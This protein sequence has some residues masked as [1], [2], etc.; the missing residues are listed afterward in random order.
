MNRI[1]AIDPEAVHRYIPKMARTWPVEDQP[2][3]LIKALKA[4]EAAKIQDGL[5]DIVP[6]GNNKDLS[7]MRIYSGSSILN[8]LVAGLSGWE[9][10]K[11]SNGEDAPWRDNNGTPRAENFDYIPSDIRKELA[12]QITEGTFLTEQDEK[13]SE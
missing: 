7:T 4:K 2:V 6:E 11:L 9:N 10:F 1:I 8:A 12:E 5:A 13:N 3:F